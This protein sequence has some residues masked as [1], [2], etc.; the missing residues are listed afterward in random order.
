MDKS[1][2]II[3]HDEKTRTELKILGLTEFSMERLANGETNYYFVNEP[4][5]MQKFNFSHKKLSYTNKLN[6]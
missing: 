5:K 2:F 1:N 3:A 4:K 6:F